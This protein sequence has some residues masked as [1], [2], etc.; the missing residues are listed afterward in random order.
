MGTFK[1]Y[2]LSSPFCI[3]RGIFKIP[4]GTGPFLLL[5][6]SG[7]PMCYRRH[8]YTFLHLYRYYRREFSCHRY[9]NLSNQHP[10]R[11]LYGCTLLSQKHGQDIP[12][13]NIFIVDYHIPVLFCI[14]ML[15]AGHTPLFFCELEGGHWR[16]P[17]KS[18][19]PYS[20]HQKDLKPAYFLLFLKFSPKN[21]VAAILIEQLRAHSLPVV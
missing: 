1:A 4:S 9:F 2:I 19:F 5:P 16:P 15:S 20:I 21:S 7:R 3:R 14:H 12:D 6:L 10:F 11:I 13:N 8:H 18:L 17:S